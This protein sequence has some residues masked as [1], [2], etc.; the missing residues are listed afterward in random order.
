MFMLYLYCIQ[1]EFPETIK[2]SKVVKFYGQTDVE[3]N[4]LELFSFLYF[5]SHACTIPLF[6]SVQFEKGIY[7]K[8]VNVDDDINNK[9]WEKN[10]FIIFEME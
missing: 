2:P 9:I 1:R 10:E 5:F 7:L 6:A 4:S 8:D 3:W